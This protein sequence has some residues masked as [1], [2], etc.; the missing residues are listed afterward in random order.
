MIEHIFLTGVKGIGKSTIISSWLKNNIRYRIGGFLTKKD[1]E[2]SVYLYPI[3]D[4]N[5]YLIKNGEEKFPEVFE[6][7]GVSSLSGSYDYIIIDE[8]GYIES[9]CFEF[10]RALDNLLSTTV[11]VLG[12]IRIDSPL[13]PILVKNDVIILTVTEENRD[14]IKKRLLYC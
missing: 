14:E 4:C 7:V 3:G 9:E 10:I 6:N 2:N 8:I 5:R 11:P 12:V 1:E 13:M